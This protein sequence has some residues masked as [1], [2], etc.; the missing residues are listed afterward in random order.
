MFIEIAFGKIGSCK[1][2]GLRPVGLVRVAN[3]G[4]IS[5]PER[6]KA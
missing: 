5:V 1:A 2:Y 3:G 6:L 4:A